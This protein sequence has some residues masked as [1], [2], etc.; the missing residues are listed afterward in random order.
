MIN[1][2]LSSFLENFVRRFRYVFAVISRPRSRLKS[3]GNLL[4]L[5]YSEYGDLHQ[6]MKSD[7]GLKSSN[8]DSNDKKGSNRS[9]YGNCEYQKSCQ[10]EKLMSSS[11]VDDVQSENQ[12]E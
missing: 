8:S 5:A 10:A 12:T 4:M 11:T 6:I 3:L 2:T 7:R 9:A 1:S